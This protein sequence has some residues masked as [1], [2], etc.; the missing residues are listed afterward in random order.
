VADEAVLGSV[1][2]ARQANERIRSLGL[3]A[4]RRRLLLGFVCECIK[5]DCL[6]PIVATLEEYD[7]VRTDPTHYLVAVGHVS[8][9]DTEKVVVRTSHY[10]VVRRRNGVDVHA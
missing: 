2:V 7:A 3:Q 4:G 5:D 10:W 8:E 1:N 9:R 6:A